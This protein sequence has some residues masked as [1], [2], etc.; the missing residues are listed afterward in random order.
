M[1]LVNKLMGNGKNANANG[2]AGRKTANSANDL[3]S[4]ALDTLGCVVRTMGEQSFALDDEA[5]LE[6][7]QETCEEL[8]CHVENG[9][10]VSAMDIAQ[11]Q[12]GSR[13]WAQVRR[14]YIDRRTNE[15]EYVTN[16]LGDYRGIVEDLVQGLKHVGE[17]DQDTEDAVRENLTVVE[18][19]VDNGALPEI[20]AAVSKTIDNVTETFARQKEDYE[21]KINE[22]NDR[23]SN[24][25]E[26]LVQA[27][28][29]MQRDSLTDTYNRGAFDSAIT[30]SLN[31]HFILNQ[32]VTLAMIDLDNFKSINDTYG[33]GAGD[34]VLRAV[35]ES[36]AR[37]FIRKSDLVARY[38]GDEFAVILSDTTANNALPAIKRFMQYMES[39][40]IPYAGEDVKV[41]CSVGYTE[42]HDDDSV[43]S[44]VHR[45]DKAL[46]ASKAAG[47]NCYHYMD[48]DSAEAH[49]DINA[50]A[51]DV[52]TMKVA[53]ADA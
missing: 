47:R 53:S 30:R 13:Q 26:D 49:A 44:L 12:D 9:A 16:R 23:M 40:R 33:H 15:K 39:V 10:A 29:K 18:N 2:G 51:N 20:K 46:Y 35:G 37:S 8:A 21:K 5:N 4:G 32:P 1:K 43:D 14:F 34:E 28:E 31:M 24:L 17:R 3:T 27:Q 38:G 50:A 41:S 48:P 22:L 52:A 7:F 42:I 19:A 45:A 6:A 36:L 25:R 11:T